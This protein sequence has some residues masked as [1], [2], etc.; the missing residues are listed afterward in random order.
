MKK[1]H[2]KFVKV[3]GN[4]NEIAFNIINKCEILLCQLLIATQPVKMDMCL[5]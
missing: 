1:V 2:I 3:K 5:R 4:E